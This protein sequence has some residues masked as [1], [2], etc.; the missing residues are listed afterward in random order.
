MPSS[1][2]AILSAMVLSMSSEPRRRP[3]PTVR[4]GCGRRRTSLDRIFPFAKKRNG[5][6]LGE[7]AGVPGHPLGASGGIEAIACIKA[8]EESWL[9][10]TLGLDE[11]DPECGL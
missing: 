7:G 4:C 10:L 9:P 8:M 6:V 3:T 11:A 1:W 2:A 5:M